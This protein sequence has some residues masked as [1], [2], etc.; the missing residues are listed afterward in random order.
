MDHDTTVDTARQFYQEL[1][2]I[3]ARIL[4]PDFT[5][6][7]YAAAGHLL[8]Y[9]APCHDSGAALPPQSQDH[10]K[11]DHKPAAKI[12]RT[13][14]HGVDTE[15]RNNWIGDSE[16][17]IQF[18]KAATPVTVS[19]AAAIQDISA[20]KSSTYY[21]LVI[22]EAKD[23]IT[24]IYATTSNCMPI[25]LDGASGYSDWCNKNA[26]SH[27]EALTRAG[28]IIG[29]YAK[30]PSNTWCTSHRT[31]LYPW[32]KPG[33]SE[34]Q[35]KNLHN[36]NSAL[37]FALRI[38][39]QIIASGGFALIRHSSIPKWAEKEAALNKLAVAQWLLKVKAVKHHTIS[40]AVHGGDK[41]FSSALTLRLPTL[42]NYIYKNQQREGI[43]LSQE[44]SINTAISKAVCDSIESQLDSRTELLNQEPQTAIDMHLVGYDPYTQSLIWPDSVNDNNLIMPEAAAFEDSL[45]QQLNL[46]HLRQRAA[47]NMHSP[48][49][50]SVEEGR[51]SAEIRAGAILSLLGSEP[52]SDT[53]IEEVMALWKCQ[54]NSKRTNVIP[55][56]QRWVHSDTLG[57]IA[58]YGEQ[59]GKHPLIIS[60]ATV[61]HEQF[62]QLLSRWAASKTPN[63]GLQH[64][65]KYTSISVN[66]GYAAKIHR[67]SNNLGPSLALAGGQYNGGEL[68]TWPRDNLQQPLTDFSIEHSTQHNSYHTAVLFN[69]KQAH[70]VLPF[71]GHRWSLVFFTASGALQIDDTM[72]QAAYQQLSI[73]MPDKQ[74]MR[75]TNYDMSN[76]ITARAHQT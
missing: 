5:E 3:L 18:H 20:F 74:S 58:P 24:T 60:Q 68:C 70:S 55:D 37:L 32:G 57:Y 46:E 1:E 42:Q 76:I 34:T 39:I 50:T 26:V 49:L 72:R 45:Q 36:E 52:P 48:G 73:P 30:P 66:I 10:T 19:Q 43:A 35:Y 14:I 67:D 61:G 53:Q 75:F 41:R 22:G 13:I 69:G 4:N 17:D 71:T 25:Y 38:F 12:Q 11:Q 65:F 62:V 40:H 44:T 15:I 2:D 56:N 16:H 28:Y 9:L 47:I 6:I 63:S 33:L 23:F 31:A 8:E 21:I 7:A 27:W 51:A 59:R 29:M 54:R 64:A